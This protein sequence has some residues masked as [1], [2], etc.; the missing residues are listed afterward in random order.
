[1]SVQMKARPFPKNRIKK[2]HVS[3]FDRRGKRGNG[4]KYGA[5]SKLVLRLRRGCAIENTVIKVKHCR[6]EDYE[7]ITFAI[8]PEEV[9]WANII[10]YNNSRPTWQKI[11]GLPGNR[12]GYSMNG[13][14]N[15]YYYTPPKVKKESN[16]L[17]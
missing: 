11:E 14:P 3:I 8:C 16:P 17:Q 4:N 2:I 10:I 6:I 13:Q 7:Q 1:M 12:R 5:Y 15:V 9:I